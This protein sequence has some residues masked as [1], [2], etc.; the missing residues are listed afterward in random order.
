[1]WFVMIFNSLVA[2]FAT[3]FCVD[4]RSRKYILYDPPFDHKVL[5]SAWKCKVA[6]YVKRHQS[7]K[8]E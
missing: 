6:T 3:T 7:I 5:Y 4:N 2:D 1:M 8:Y